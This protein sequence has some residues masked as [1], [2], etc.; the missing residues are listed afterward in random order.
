MRRP[1][2]C[3]A[4]TS[5]EY[6]TQKSILP[7]ASFGHQAGGDERRDG[8]R[9]VLVHAWCLIPVAAPEDCGR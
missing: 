6:L 2:G 3:T 8:R 4:P 1:Q 7:Q 9:A 5:A